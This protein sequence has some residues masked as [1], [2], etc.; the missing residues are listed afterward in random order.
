MINSNEKNW[1]NILK[2]EI[3]KVRD[4]CLLV[5]NLHSYVVPSEKFAEKFL[6]IIYDQKIKIDIIQISVFGDMSIINENEDINIIKVQ[7]NPW[8]YYT[9]RKSNFSDQS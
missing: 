9:R 3:K 7:E 6:K 2:K 4:K 1:E 5:V 8:D